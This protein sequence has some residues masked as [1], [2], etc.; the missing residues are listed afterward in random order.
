MIEEIISYRRQGMSFRKIAEKL[1]STVG[2]VHYQWI[3]NVKDE[4]NSSSSSNAS[5]SPDSNKHYSI[6][7]KSKDKTYKE[8][9]YLVSRL[10]E[11]YKIASFWKIAPWQKQLV[12]SYFNIDLNQ[13]YVVFRIYDV[14]DIIFNGS[15]AHS[16][17]EFQLPENKTYWIIKGI[18]PGRSYVTEVGYRLDQHQ[19]FPILRSN[20][21]HGHKTLVEKNEDRL[22]NRE[23]IQKNMADKPN[24]VGNVSTYSFYENI[25]KGKN[26]DEK[27]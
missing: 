19:F 24:W 13:R 17:F 22:L 7:V 4:P 16:V 12:T 23:E 18:K 11:D 8:D 3:K 20:A 9:Q 21:I 10:V 6:K 25:N 1:N 27:I 26:E 2:K 5:S 15:N 14:T